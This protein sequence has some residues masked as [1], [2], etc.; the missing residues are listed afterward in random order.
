MDKK[1][2]KAWMELT[3]SSGDHWLEDEG[4]RMNGSG[5]QYYRGCE[6]GVYLKIQRDGKLEIGNYVGELPHIEESYS[7]PVVRKR[8]EDFSTAFAKA[9]EFM[10]DNFLEDIFF[11]QNHANTAVGETKAQAG[12][13][14]TN[15]YCPLVVHAEEEYGSDYIEI[16]NEILR[17]YED[18]IRGAIISETRRGD[19]KDMSKYFNGIQTLKTKLVSIQWDVENV[20]HDVYG[21]IHV[22]TTEPLTAEEKEELSEWITGQS[23]DGF[24]EGLEQRPITTPDGDIYVSFWNSENYFLLE[25]DEFKDM[26]CNGIQM[27]GML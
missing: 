25:D 23:A 10:G 13:T 11:T 1:E 27:G 15:F 19:R 9:I 20:N 4:Y 21:C 17:D 14:H 26:M 6:K 16:D 18:I 7:E 8:Y 24:G 2:I 3:E 5:M 22:D 12:H